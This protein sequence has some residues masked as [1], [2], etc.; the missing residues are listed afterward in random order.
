MNIVPNIYQSVIGD[1]QKLAESKNKLRSYFSAQKI[2]RQQNLGNLEDI[3]K[4]ILSNQDKQINESKLT[5][6]KLDE[7]RAELTNILQ[8][9]VVNG[10]LTN[11]ASEVI[12]KKLDKLDKGY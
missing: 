11:A 6:S 7:S 1:L 4:P 10:D 8:Q 3:Y 2:S 9:L 5:N 12:V